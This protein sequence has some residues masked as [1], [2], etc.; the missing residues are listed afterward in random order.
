[1]PQE[2][3]FNDSL[4]ALSQFFVGDKTMQ[5]TLDRVAGV[6]AVALPKAELVGITM[7][8]N[9]RLQTAVFTDPASPE[10]DQAQY[11]SRSGPCLDAFRTGDIHRIDAMESERRWPEFREACLEHGVLSTLSLPLSVEEQTYGALN[12]YA[13]TEH[14]FDS[15]DTETACLFASQAAIVLANATA[16]WS[17]RAK[18]EQLEAALASRAVIEQAKGIIISTMRCTADEAFGILTK[19]SQ[20]QNRKLREIATEI[21][22]FAG[23]RP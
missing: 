12:L 18:A 17:A 9:G 21:V 14:A 5:Q 2:G 10:I 23:R 19:Q 11:D 6:T 22:T 15:P 1:M 4:S 3:A 20:Q 16:Y 8:T 13:K 7:M